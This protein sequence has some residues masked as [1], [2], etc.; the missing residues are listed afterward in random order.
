MDW[1]V[2]VL[3]PYIDLTFPTISDRN[4]TAICG[5]SMGGLMALYSAVSYQ[6]VFSKAACLSPSMWVNPSNVI[7]MVQGCD[8]SREML[9]YMDYGDE[10]MSNHAENP[11][12]LLETER[13]LRDRGAEVTLQII[14]GGKH[15]EASWEKRIPDFMKFLEL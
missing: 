6:N 13:I 4:H 1:L 5:S 3:K 8:I 11:G 12:I 15:C 9:I 10:E 14:P 2:R 7:K